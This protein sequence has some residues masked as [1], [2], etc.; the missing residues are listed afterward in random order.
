MKENIMSL[1]GLQVRSISSSVIL[2]NGKYKRDIYAHYGHHYYMIAEI[3]AD[4]SQFENIRPGGV[5][6]ATVWVNSTVKEDRRVFT[7]L[8]IHTIT[9][10]QNKHEN[11]N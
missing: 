6:D 9:E 11:S 8:L 10:N 1:T 5:Y 2:N 3:V 4:Q 7:N